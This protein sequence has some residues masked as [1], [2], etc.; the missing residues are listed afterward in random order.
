MKKTYPEIKLKRHFLVW[1]RCYKRSN[2]FK[3]EKMWQVREEPYT[4]DLLDFCTECFKTNGEVR[5]YL[6]R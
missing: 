2:W 6:N 5:R 3:Y 1:T 4:G